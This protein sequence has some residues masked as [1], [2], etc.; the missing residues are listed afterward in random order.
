[1][2]GSVLTP[3]ELG[4][5]SLRGFPAFCPFNWIQKSESSLVK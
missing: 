5:F 3:M 1:M 2:A 4:I